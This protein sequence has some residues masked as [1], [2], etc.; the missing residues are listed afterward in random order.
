MIKLLRKIFFILA[1]AATTNTYIRIKNRERTLTSRD[2]LAMFDLYKLNNYIYHLTGMTIEIMFF[3]HST[4]THLYYNLFFVMI[5]N[6]E[7][8]V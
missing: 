4:S 2:P 6:A 1:V 7:D 3:T 5:I 8:F